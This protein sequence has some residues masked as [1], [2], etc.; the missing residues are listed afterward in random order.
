MGIRLYY[1]S[2]PEFSGLVADYVQFGA[3]CWYE[4]VTLQKFMGQCTNIYFA[5]F[6]LKRCTGFRNG[7]QNR[8]LYCLSEDTNI[9]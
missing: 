9:H 4:V 3:T 1:E 8:L 7:Q 6:C 2:A 5:L